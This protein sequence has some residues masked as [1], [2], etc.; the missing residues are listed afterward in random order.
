MK[1]N[2]L[3]YVILASTLLSFSACTPKMAGQD[4]A[5]ISQNRGALGAQISRSEAEQYRRQ[6]ELSAN[7][8]AVEN[9]KRRQTTDSIREGAEAASSVSNAIRGGVG[10]VRSLQGLIGW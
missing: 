7:E 4:S 1:K 3:V 6:Q 9:M 5:Y 10:A 2:V 8:M